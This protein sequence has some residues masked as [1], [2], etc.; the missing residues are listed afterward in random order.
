MPRISTRT[1][2][3]LLLA[4]AAFGA[5]LPARASARDVVERFDFDLTGGY[6]TDRI[7][8]NIAGD[9]DGGNP[10]V[11]SELTWED[12]E[13]YQVS[14]QG[15]LIMAN[16]RFPFGGML[17]GG[18]SFGDINSGANQDSDYS[19][20][21]RTGEYSRSNNRA[22]SGNVW[23]GSLGGGVIFFNHSRTFSLAPAVGFSYHEQ[24]LTIHD[25]YQTLNDP[26]NT[27]V[28]LTGQIPAVGPI[29]GLNSNYEAQWRTGWLGLDV[30]YMP[31]PFFDIHGK[32]EFHSGKYEAEADW[33][34]RSN[35]QHP[36]SFRHTTNKAT[37]VV[38]GVGIRAGHPN[39]FFTI[40]YLY[41]KWQAEDG[42]D[43]TY[44]SDGT[45]SDTRLNEVNWEAASINAGM[46]VRF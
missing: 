19:G 26:A 25:G 29:A 32:A 21:G 16:K 13:S 39:L 35:F 30:E 5:F 6:R 43:R 9:L 17:R 2:S 37:G 15:K 27:P 18:V 41:Q 44:F 11:L 23:D 28:S 10:N 45:T 31:A 14:A 20:D 3:F 46:T 24:N 42:V 8:W 33:N 4:G 38:A 12:L 1:V 40:D 22:D 34:L 36:K 7:D